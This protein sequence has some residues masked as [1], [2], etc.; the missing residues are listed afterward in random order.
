MAEMSVLYLLTHL[1]ASDE[2]LNQSNQAGI[3][4]AIG[5]LTGG[6]NIATLHDR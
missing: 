5:A 4:P 3:H 2:L 1:A 6:D